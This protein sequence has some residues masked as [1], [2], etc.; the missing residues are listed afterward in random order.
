[1]AT[2]VGE[3]T[4]NASKNLGPVAAVT[5]VGLV[6]S[7]RFFLFISLNSV[8]ILF[9]DQWDFLRIFFDHD[10]GMWELFVLQH[11]PHREGVG[12]IADKFLYPLTHWNVRAESFMI[13]GCIFIAM[14]LALVLKKQLFGKIAYSDVAIPIMFLT[15]AQY[16]TLIGTPNPAY[17]GFP[18]LLIMLYALAHLQP[19]YLLRYGMLLLINLLLIYTGFGVF[20]GLITIGLFALD[21]YWCLRGALSLRPVVPLSGFLM[22][23]ATLGSFFV[24]YKFQ[25]AADC[26]EFPYHNLA[27]YPWFMALMFPAFAGMKGHIL[28][29][30]L[31]GIVI[32]SFALYVFARQVLTLL[33]R[34]VRFRS[35][36]LTMAVMLAYSLL[37]S[38]NTAVGRVCLGLPAAAQPSRYTTLLIPAF[39]AMYFFL[40]T[41]NEEPLR[42]ILLALFVLLLL[43]GH[44][45]KPRTVDWFANGKR[46]WA[47][48]Y[49]QKE[50]VAYCD[51]LTNF[52]VY[53]DAGRTRLKQKLDYLKQHRL[54]LFAGP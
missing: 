22:A 8:N 43:P 46:A 47:A 53:P 30:T 26:F 45:H 40:L 2:S 19:S 5:I 49:K 42:N 39:L 11:G 1:M 29:V 24:K 9:W 13:G 16:E 33:Q 3:P 14:L 32:L 50:D 44:V 41:M 10:P 12:L 38:A 35:V 36:H 6:L 4:S 15:L 37:F 28:L 48:C 34:E 54:N 21:Y 52:R 31:L 51:S 17:S 25:P 7:V 20:I 27:A 23:C 18:L